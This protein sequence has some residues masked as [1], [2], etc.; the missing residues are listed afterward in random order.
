MVNSCSRI[1]SLWAAACLVSMVAWAQSST[2]GTIEGRVRDQA[3]N[4]IQGAPVTGIANRA[5]A[6]A[7]T[8][9]QALHARQPAP[10]TYK[11]RAEAPNKPPWCSTISSSA[12]ARGP[13]RYHARRRPDRDGNG[14][15]SST[16]CRREVGH[17]GGTYKVEGMPINYPSGATGGH[18]NPQPGVS[19][20]GAQVPAQSISGSGLENSTSSTANITS[21]G[22][23]GM[24]RITPIMGRSGPA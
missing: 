22:Y 13:R 18:A 2:T 6:A 8:D 4:A 7:V 24:V 10:G 12:S 11:V 3:G 23:G 5:P 19:S 21:T 17:D 16:R 14:H 1:L 9:S 15:R 20:G